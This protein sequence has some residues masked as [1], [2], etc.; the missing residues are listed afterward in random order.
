MDLAQNAQEGGTTD[1][2]N[3]ASPGVTL[4][5]RARFGGKLLELL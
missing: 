4:T 3:T 1:S 2:D 5:N